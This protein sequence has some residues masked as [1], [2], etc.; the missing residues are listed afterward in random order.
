MTPSYT[1]MRIGNKKHKV[2]MHIFMWKTLD[3][4]T[5]NREER[6]PLYQKIST[7]G[8]SCEQLR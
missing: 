4:K 2:R 7:R 1:I 5:V 3:K 8:K 6:N